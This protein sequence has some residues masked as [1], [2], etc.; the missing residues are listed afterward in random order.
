[1]K[2]L[3]DLT[4]EERKQVLEN[5]EKFRQV[6]YESCQQALNFMLDDL[7]SILFVEPNR[8]KG[9]RYYDNYNSF[10]FRL[11]DAEEF[12]NGLNDRIGDYFSESDRPV[13]EKM[14]KLA[15]EYWNLEFDDLH[16]EKGEKI[17]NELEESA[18]K[19]LG[20]IENM[21]HDYE[22]PTDDMIDT[23]LEYI[24]GEDSAISEYTIDDDGRI[25]TGREIVWR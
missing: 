1:M 4:A 17:Y 12:V 13:Y 14:L 8:S 10:Y 25:H 3:K 21:F 24:C 18:K 7:N 20:A 2:K 5:N 23:E 16:G 22:E 11:T 6:V 19:V 9:Y 15:D